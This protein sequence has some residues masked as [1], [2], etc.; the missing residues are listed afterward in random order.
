L[1]ARPGCA[2]ALF[3]SGRGRSFPA[4]ASGFDTHR[5]SIT[6][7]MTVV[8]TRPGYARELLA[9]DDGEE[10]CFEEVDS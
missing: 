8:V 6:A 5:D 7:M 1:N 2:T 4:N 10:L 9:S 3:L